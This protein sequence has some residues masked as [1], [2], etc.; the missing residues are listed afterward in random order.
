MGALPN[1]RRLTSTGPAPSLLALALEAWARLPEELVGSIVPAQRG[2]GALPPNPVEHRATG[3]AQSLGCRPEAGVVSPVRRQIPR[4]R[5]RLMD[6]ARERAAELAADMAGV[7]YALRVEPDPGFEYISPSIESLIG[8]TPEQLMASDVPTLVRL[9]HHDDRGMVDQIV[10]APYDEVIELSFRWIAADGSVVWARHRAR[11]ERRPDGSV[12]LFGAAQDASAEASARAALA[13]SELLYRLVAENAADIVFR[14]DASDHY[15]WV[16]PSVADRLGWRV[17]EVVG[18]SPFDLVHPD[19]LATLSAVGADA[20]SGQV[21][22]YEARIRRADGGYSWFSIASR[23]VLD[24]TGAVRGRV[25]GAR[26]IDAEVE[27]REALV[28]SEHLYRLLAENSLDVVYRADL[29]HHIGWVSPSITEVLGWEPRDLLGQHVS[30]IANPDDVARAKRVTRELIDTGGDAGQ[31]EMRFRTKDG[32]WRWMR[33]TGRV[34]RDPDG[35]PQGGIDVLR[36]IQTEVE[37]RQRLQ[38][39]VDHDP[40]TGLA[41]RSRALDLVRD[42][43][44]RDGAATVLVVGLDD[45]KAVNEALTF[46]AGDQ[47]LRSVAER[48]TSEVGSHELVARVAGNEFAVLQPGLS[49]ADAAAALAVR[50]LDAVRGSVRIGVHDLETSVTIGIA[51]ATTGSAEDLLSDASTALHQAKSGGRGRW[52]FLDPTVSDSARTS[53]VVQSRL[54][55]ALATGQ[56]RAWFQPIVGLADDAV[57]GYEALVRWEHDDG[58]IGAPDTFIPTAERTNLIVDLDRVVLRDALDLLARLPASQ[59]VSVNVSAASLSAPELVAVVEQALETASVDPSRLHLEITETSLVHV[60]D[61]VQAAMR[62]LAARGVRWYVDDFGTGYSS[63]T[64]LRDLPI[65]GL[66]LD[67]SFTAGLGSGDV[68]SER[69]A[70]GL[71]GLADGLELDTVAEGVETR[72]QAEALAQQGWVHGQGWLFGRPVPA[73][74]IP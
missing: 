57:R 31:I 51:M 40:L 63:I 39:E 20:A 22:S 24:E 2:P 30:V 13:E 21:A 23:P 58:T 17:E 60:T 45:L 10:S 11:K 37:T 56:I 73:V 64:H 59:H 29:T 9:V 28:E 72:T 34:L 4:H 26:I 48:L 43:L 8:Y 52:E 16:S 47:V 12:V 5:R 27:A 6:H 62:T 3:A 54:R 15:E 71:A 7:L 14:V 53:I 46:T 42:S 49:D 32:R 61:K 55:D 65:A 25:G 44:D 36:D 19:D 66:K 38:H 50:L 33:V 69:L 74:S 68:V 35:V 70:D 18:R 67:R 1:L 41:N